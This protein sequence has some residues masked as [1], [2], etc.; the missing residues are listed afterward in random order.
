MLELNWRSLIRDVCKYAQYFQFSWI[1]KSECGAQVEIRH[2]HIHAHTHSANTPIYTSSFKA[3]LSSDDCSDSTKGSHSY[4]ISPQKFNKS[5]NQCNERSK[6]DKKIVFC[7]FFL[8]ICIGYFRVFTIVTPFL[9][10][11]IEITF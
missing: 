10:F 4:Q 8:T 1:L 11:V 9:Y 3:S 6:G 5:S 2:K 7:I